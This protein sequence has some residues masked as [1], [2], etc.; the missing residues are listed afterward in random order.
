MPTYKINLRLETGRIYQM[1]NKGST[2]G[3]IVVLLLYCEF[4]ARGLVTDIFV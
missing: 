3:G 1:I 4:H 2:V